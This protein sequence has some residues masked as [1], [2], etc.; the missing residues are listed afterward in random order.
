MQF[1]E[2]R[3]SEKLA[4][5]GNG[6]GQN[7]SSVSRIL[8]VDDEESLREICQDALVDEGYEVDLAEDGQAALEYLAH[9][10]NIDLIVSDLRMPQMNGIDLLKRVREQKLDVDFLVMTGF[11]TIET[12]VECMKLG[13]SDYLPK[14]FNINHLLVKVNKVLGSRKSRMEHKRLGNIVR[15]LNLSNALNA[16][17]DPKSI[18]YEFIS[19]IQKNFK[20][21][22]ACLFLNNEDKE[23]S[24]SIIRGVIFRTRQDIFSFV[25]SLC[26]ESM[27]NQQSK[28]IDQYNFPENDRFKKDDFPYSL[29]IVPLVAQGRGIGVVALI[30]E[31]KN[32]LFGHTDVQLL[33]VFASHV[34]T[35]MQNANMYARMQDLNLDII[36]S[37]ATAVEVKDVYTKGH[38]ERV[39]TYGLKLGMELGLVSRELEKIYVAGVLHD[40]GKIGV[41]DNILNKPGRLTDEEFEVMKKHPTIGR[42]ILSQVWSLKDILPIVY[43]HHER[44][45]GKGYPEGLHG[46][47]IPFL[48]RV[49]SVVDAFE[50]MTSDRAYRESLPMDKVKNILSEGAGT[51]WQ[52]DIVHKWLDFVETNDLTQIDENNFSGIRELFGK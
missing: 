10:S 35:S 43:Y 4:R 20:P 34:A 3:E 18:S 23:A 11:G 16:Q 47:Q 39:A 45:D 7:E 6:S 46:D 36:R 49:I 21:D 52:E 51:Q 26:L 31:K 48:A 25:R 32:G 28:L 38:S 41:P 42:D 24:S 5:Q 27:R 30:R 29:L 33:S 1:S 19:H 15:M 13:A 12:A 50:A 44:V 9:N 2:N 40:I 22:S 8:V 17:L 14:P 37:Y